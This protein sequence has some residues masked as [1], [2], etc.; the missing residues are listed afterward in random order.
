MEIVVD[1]KFLYIFLNIN[2]INNFFQKIII[3]FLTN[4][5][6]NLDI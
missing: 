2:Y 5:T 6:S 4:N 1:F 3:N